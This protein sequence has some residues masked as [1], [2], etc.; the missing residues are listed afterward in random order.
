MMLRLNY[1]ASF[2]LG[3]TVIALS[4]LAN[5][6]NFRE[7]LYQVITLRLSIGLSKK[8]CSE[9]KNIQVQ[10][11]AHTLYHIST[12]VDF[13]NPQ[14]SQKFRY[15]TIARTPGSVVLRFIVVRSTCVENKFS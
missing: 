12:K 1:F 11:L 9:K 14:L 2:I 6:P 15:T 3:K 10:S 8:L 4:V 5:P 7:E 13:I